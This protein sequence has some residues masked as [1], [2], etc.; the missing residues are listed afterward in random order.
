MNF[1][2]EL[3]IYA[4]V[5]MVVAGLAFVAHSIITIDKRLRKQM[6]ELQQKLVAL[7]LTGAPRQNDRHL[8]GEIDLTHPKTGERL[9]AR[10]R[11]RVIDG[12]RARNTHRS[13][14]RRAPIK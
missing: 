11:F 12:G 7:Y 6:L 1:G 14:V 13:I 9:T 8:E 3:T 10:A 5:I 4:I 2:A